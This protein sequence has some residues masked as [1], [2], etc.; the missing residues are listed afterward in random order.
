MKK[1]LERF[2]F[3]TVKDVA[4]KVYEEKDSVR[5]MIEPV[6]E[7]KKTIEIQYKPFDRYERGE[8]Q[9]IDDHRNIRIDRAYSVLARDGDVDWDFEDIYPCGRC[10]M[11]RNWHNAEMTKRQEADKQVERLTNLIINIIEKLFSVNKRS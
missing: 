1:K 6:P 3:A 7:A 9:L 4:I 2:K 5:V 10:A 8:F 11:E